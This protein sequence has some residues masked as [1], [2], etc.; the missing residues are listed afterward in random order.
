MTH[1]IYLIT[2]CKGSHLLFVTVLLLYLFIIIQ[3]NAIRGP[4]KKGQAEA[5]I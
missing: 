2:L 4:K 3:I 1:I 5:K